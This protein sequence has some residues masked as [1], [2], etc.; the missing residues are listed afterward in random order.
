[1]YLRVPREARELDRPTSRRSCRPHAS[2]RRPASSAAAAALSSA[3]WHE[4]GRHATAAPQAS[5]SLYTR[6]R[7]ASKASKL[8]FGRSK[9]SKLRYSD[10]VWRTSK[11]GQVACVA[12]VGV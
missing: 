2:C 10:A 12:Y 4:L 7:K 5:E 11:Q 9:A 3:N 1:M 8:I 6:S